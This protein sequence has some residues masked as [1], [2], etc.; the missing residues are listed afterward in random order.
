MYIRERVR[1]FLKVGHETMYYASF[2]KL[3]FLDKIWLPDS[4]DLRMKALFLLE[5]WMYEGLFWQGNP[6]SDVTKVIANKSFGELSPLV[7]ISD[8]LS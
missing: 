2:G 7:Q 5:T 4:L 1:F 3:S 8:S 6:F